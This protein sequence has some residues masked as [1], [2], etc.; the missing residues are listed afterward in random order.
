MTFKQAVFLWQEIRERDTLWK[1]I[2]LIDSPALAIDD[3]I[4]SFV[5]L[6]RDWAEA[7]EK[8]DPSAKPKR[9]KNRGNNAIPA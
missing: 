8:G 9:K 4:E 2:E 7:L 6:L 3:P 1:H 5:A